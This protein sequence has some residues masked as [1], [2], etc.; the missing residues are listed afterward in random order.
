MAM[1]ADFTFVLRTA[2]N[3]GSAEIRIEIAGIR[4]PVIR[5]QAAWERI[6]SAT[7]S[8]KFIALVIPQHPGSNTNLAQIVEALG[9]PGP[10]TAA[11]ETGQEHAGEDRDNGHHHQQ[12]D[13]CEGEPFCFHGQSDSHGGFLT[14]T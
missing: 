4:H 7:H 2:E 14:V 12:L 8:S 3:L 5:G 13:E 6:A 1:L 10:V 9:F 11:C